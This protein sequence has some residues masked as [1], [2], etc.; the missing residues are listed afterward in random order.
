MA[1]RA[2]CSDCNGYVL[3]TDEGLCPHGHP[4]PSLRGIEE[5]NGGPTPAPR[6]QTHVPSATQAA[7]PVAEPTPSTA[8]AP[9]YDAA[10]PWAA[11]DP[12]SATPSAASP[13]AP[14][15][16]RP[17]LGVPAAPCLEQ[18]ASSPSPMMLDTLPPTDNRGVSVWKLLLAAV[19]IAA[20]GLGGYKY[21]TRPKNGTIET[22]NNVVINVPK[23]WTMV[24]D[25]P[26]QF[27]V[28]RE[29]NDKIAVQVDLHVDKRA[30][31]VLSMQVAEARMSGWPVSETTWMG[32]RAIA[33]GFEAGGVQEQ[34][35]VMW[36]GKLRTYV[37][38]ADAP[39]A[40]YATYKPQIDQMIQG[41]QLVA[42]KE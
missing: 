35:T 25:K 29:G 22:M 23:G 8:P 24:A 9:A 1:R 6:P 36:D 40:E 42:P 21:F 26:T 30:D 18:N 16:A 33:F 11:S 7:T 3:L 14:P 2:W 17:S 13:A 28:T 32:K 19:L 27:L 39:A 38:Y 5:W 37:V 4:K 12:L 10:R 34:R 15:S 31:V 41:M 20:I